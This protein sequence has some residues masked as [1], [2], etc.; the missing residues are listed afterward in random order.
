MKRLVTLTGVV[1]AV[2]T[3]AAP[4]DAARNCA[5]G[6]EQVVPR[7]RNYAECMA[8][9]RVLQCA[10]QGP[11]FC[12]G[13][14]LQVGGSKARQGCLEKCRSDRRAAGIAATGG[15]FCLKQCGAQ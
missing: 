15:G 13:N 4:A 1:F 8:N 5:T 10:A 14:F 3:L 12:A 7:P 6:Q 11:A 2:I 9:A